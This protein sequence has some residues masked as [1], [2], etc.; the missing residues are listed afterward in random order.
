[1]QQ[2]SNKVDSGSTPLSLSEI[3]ARQIRRGKGEGERIKQASSLN[4]ALMPNQPNN[5]LRDLWKL[6][7]TPHL[8][9]Y[10]AVKNQ[11]RGFDLEINLSHMYFRH[12]STNEIMLQIPY[13]R[14]WEW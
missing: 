9:N 1:M 8:T 11:R 5:P 13:T 7:Q 6:R 10:S 2:T 12:Q 4:A 3:F 14:K